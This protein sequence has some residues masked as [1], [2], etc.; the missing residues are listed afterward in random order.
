MLDKTQTELVEMQWEL[1]T[2]KDNLGKVLDEAKVDEVQSRAAAS[3]LMQ[4]E[5]AIKG[6]HLAL[7]VRI[8]NVLTPEQQTRLRAAR[9]TERCAGQRDGGTN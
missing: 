4:R 5:N 6:A 8:K 2:E 3:S 1:Q 9:E 7:L